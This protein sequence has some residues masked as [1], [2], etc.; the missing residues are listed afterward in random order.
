MRPNANSV[1]GLELLVYAALSYCVIYH[2]LLA[3]LLGVLFC[4]DDL[5][6]VKA[7]FLPVCR[8]VVVH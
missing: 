6:D 1:C 3:L 8:I 5:I 4:L 2:L 7:D